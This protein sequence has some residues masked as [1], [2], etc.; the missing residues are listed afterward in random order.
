MAL[1][2]VEVDEEVWELVKK[3]AIP[4]EDTFNSALKRMLLISAEAPKPK[5]ENNILAEKVNS[6]ESKLQRL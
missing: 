5:R 1:R 2:K 6:V 3:N 4:L